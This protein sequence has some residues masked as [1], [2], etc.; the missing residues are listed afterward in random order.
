M[1]VDF[2]TQV[3]PSDGN[4]SCTVVATATVV[5]YPRPTTQ[6]PNANPLLL[7][8]TMLRPTTLL[9]PLRERNGSLSTPLT[10]AE[11]PA[12]LLL[13]PVS[14]PVLPILPTATHSASEH[15]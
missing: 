9:M 11:V 14:K 6:V 8:M 5:S 7:E 2:K 3:A 15:Q 12:A 10:K 1:P 13:A 4:W